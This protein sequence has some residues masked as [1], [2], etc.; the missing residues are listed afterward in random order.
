MKLVIQLTLAVLFLALAACSKSDRGDVIRSS[1]DLVTNGPSA[2]G[3]VHANAKIFFVLKNI[4]K[5]QTYT[6]RAAVGQTLLSDGTPTVDGTLSVNIYKSQDDYISSQA[7]F[8][9]AVSAPTPNENIYEAKF[10]AP[11]SGDYVA[12][13][14]GRSLSTPGIQF[15]YDLRLMSADNTVLTPFETTTISE[16]SSATSGTITPLT[17]NPG[18]LNV[19]SGNTITP[20]G[21]Y[22]INLTSN[23]TT[24]Q[25]YPQLFV[26]RDASLA[27]GSLLYSS[28][29]TSTDF[30]VTKFDMTTG[31]SNTLPADAKNSLAGG[32]TIPGVDFLNSAPFIVVKGIFSALTYSLTVGP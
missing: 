1:G 10:T 12:V 30:I 17:I 21:A 9:F 28:Y 2:D 24:T 3:T 18:Y 7:T 19:F 5:D 11:S 15:F 14:S 13:I 23:S 25:G 32:V 6:L 29:T 26:Y 31:I 22:P 4:N 16:A 8:T 20:P 27:L